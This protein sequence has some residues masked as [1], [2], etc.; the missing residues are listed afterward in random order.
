MLKRL[1][2]NQELD[3]FSRSLSLL[4]KS[5][6]S[7]LK[8]LEISIAGIEDQRLKEELK[9][10]YQNV[11]SG[12]T[13]SKS[14]DNLTSLPN[15]FT[16]MIA[17][18]EESGKL[19]DVLDEISHSYVQQIESDTALITSLLEPVLILTLGVILGTIVLSILLPIFQMTSMV[20]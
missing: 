1:T 18:G 17:V 9:K 15:F 8:S 10:V 5:G 13:I 11:A 19:S 6:V 20:R 12:Q 14:M 3:Y 4:L 2:Q 7:A 16:K